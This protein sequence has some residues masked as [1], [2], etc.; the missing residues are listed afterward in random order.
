MSKKFV[1]GIGQRARN[2]KDTVAN[3][4]KELRH[5]HEI[6]VLHWADALYEEV[7]NPAR[8]YPLIKRVTVG[9]ATYY[10]LLHTPYSRNYML[11][12]AEEIPVIDELMRSRN[13]EEYWG[14]NEKDAPILQAWGTNFRRQKVK[15]TYWVDRTS[16]AISLAVQE[17][18]SKHLE[19]TKNLYICIPDT[20][21][22]NEFNHVKHQTFATG[23]FV[24]VVRLNEDGTQYIDADRDP[25]HPSEA[26]LEGVAADFTLEAKSGDLETLRLK[27]SQFLDE[28]DEKW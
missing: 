9:D 14:M 25:N 12:K 18:E 11:Y 26:D 20:R 2:G 7:R 5:S 24:R 1:I 21:F 4:I 28:I 13:I 3:Y 15:E 6:C 10:N 23:V 8:Q 22:K 17:F 19:E 16:E 27:T